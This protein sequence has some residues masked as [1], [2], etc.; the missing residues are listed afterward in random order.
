MRKV[1]V[2]QPNYVC[3][4]DHAHELTLLCEDNMSKVLQDD[5]GHELRGQD[6]AGT[7]RSPIFGTCS[8]P[9][10]VVTPSSIEEE[11]PLLLLI[12][13]QSH[14]PEK[15]TAVLRM[16]ICAQVVEHDPE[17]EEI[18]WLSLAYRV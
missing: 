18:R 2:Q 17:K 1:Q 7:N 9:A 12:D 11:L 3:F 10:L 5:F 14:H 15:Q 16:Y 4:C 6:R 13:S 8:P